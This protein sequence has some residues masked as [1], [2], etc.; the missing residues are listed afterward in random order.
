MS[1]ARRAA[2]CEYCP[3][4]ACEQGMGVAPEFVESNLDC[5][6]GDE[7]ASVAAAE[8]VTMEL[9]RRWCSSLVSSRFAEVEDRPEQMH[10]SKSRRCGDKFAQGWSWQS[11]LGYYRG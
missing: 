7:L 3:A 5:V 11:V 6:Q 9:L 10:S 1:W 4:K 2:G 8:I